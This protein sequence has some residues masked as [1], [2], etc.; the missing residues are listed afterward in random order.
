MSD[1]SWWNAATEPDQ[2]NPESLV[3]SASADI[4]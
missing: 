3:T 1:R 2:T 4:E